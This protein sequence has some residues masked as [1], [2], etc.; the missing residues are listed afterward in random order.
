MDTQQV[1]D[2]V[3]AVKHQT[4][5]EALLHQ[6]FKHLNPDNSIMG[7]SNPI[8]SAYTKL[9]TQQLTPSQTDWLTWWMYETDFGNSSKQ[10]TISENDWINTRDL[11]FDKFWEMVNE[12]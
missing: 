1:Y 3:Q 7:T 5:L 10:F 4:E 11:T 12:A 8:L 2:Y 6:A 9:V